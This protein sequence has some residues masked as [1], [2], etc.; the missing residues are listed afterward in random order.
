MEQ[1][2]R[3]LGLDPFASVQ[4]SAKLGT[5]VASFGPRREDAAREAARDSSRSSAP[6]RK[7][8]RL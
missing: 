2:D 8:L 7:A 4:V 3:D 1:I 5:G 6:G